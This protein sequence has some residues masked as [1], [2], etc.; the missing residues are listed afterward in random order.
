MRL[1]D[2]D[3][4][5]TITGGLV[6]SI[7]DHSNRPWAAV[8]VMRALWDA[9]YDVYRPDDCEQ[10]EITGATFTDD[11]APGTIGLIVEVPSRPVTGGPAQRVALVPIEGA[12]RA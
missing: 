4:I 7:G 12:S 1:M 5:D 6:S 2:S 9:G 10:G 8:K 11:I 3:V